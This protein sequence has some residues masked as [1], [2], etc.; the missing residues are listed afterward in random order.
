MGN[1]CVQADISTRIGA[2]ELIA[3]ADL[4][5]DDVADASAVAAAIEDAESHIDSY[6]Q[7]K[8]AV[9]VDPVPDVLV[10]RAT[11]LAVYFLQLRRNSV[12]DDMR[13]EVKR[14]DAWLA[15]VV[16]G[17]VELGLSPK[18]TPSASAPGVHWSAKTRVFGRDEP[19]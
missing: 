2:D 8:F 5:G 16:D 1:Y 15:L 19:L 13:E 14:I 3:L 11:T 10:K 12:T 4:N 6:L 18:P 17:K 9:P 7:V